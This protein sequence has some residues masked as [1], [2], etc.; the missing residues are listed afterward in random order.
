MFIKLIKRRPLYPIS[1]EIIQEQTANALDNGSIF[2]PYSSDIG[3]L[4]KGYIPAKVNHIY[5]KTAGKAS[6]LAAVAEKV[7]QKGEN[8]NSM[9]EL[10]EIPPQVVILSM[11][12]K[13]G[14]FRVLLR[15]L[16][17]SQ[18][19]GLA[20]LIHHYCS[21]FCLFSSCVH[22]ENLI[23]MLKLR[24]TTTWKRGFHLTFVSTRLECM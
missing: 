18:M 4:W 1:L 7:L 22:R 12:T 24:S 9:V 23:S 5:G 8:P 10:G 3:F 13:I 17:F 2:V 15:M 14:F 20:H 6:D 11:K 16:I 21:W 19:M